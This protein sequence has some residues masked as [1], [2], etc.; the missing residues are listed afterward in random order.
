[1]NY[2]ILKNEL[3]RN[4]IKNV[5]LLYGDEPYLIDAVV[6]KLESVVLN[7]NINAFTKNTFS[8]DV[9][10]YDM[11]NAVNTVPMIGNSKVVVCRNSSFFTGSKSKEELL[12]LFDSISQNTCL[13]FIEEKVDK[14]NMA[15]KKLDLMKCTYDITSRSDHELTDFIRNRFAKAGKKISSNQLLT[16]LDYSGTQLLDIEK[17]IEK[18]LLYMDEKL[19]VKKEYIVN[20][21]QGSQEAKLYELVNGT[22]E[23]N[24]DK[25]MGTLKELMAD[26]T[27]V[28]LIIATLNSNYMELYEVKL[29]IE[30]NEKPEIFRFKRPINDYALKKLTEYAKKISL[31]QLKEYIKEISD[32][33]VAIKYGNISDTTAVELL[34][35]SLARAEGRN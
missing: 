30:N 8:D 3:T 24:I 31:M 34:V 27:P 33:D 13:I 5:Y 1:M 28:M 18:I 12:D 11:I 35:F 26:K 29:A 16:F 17:D 7:D 22:F 19:D 25:A 10:L 14:K 21:C 23:K 9:D 2:E 15:Y 6:K 20:L 4:L 32:T